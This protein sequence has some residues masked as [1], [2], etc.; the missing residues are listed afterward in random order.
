MLMQ[1]DAGTRTYSTTGGFVALSDA[2]EKLVRQGALERS[3]IRHQA[4]VVELSKSSHF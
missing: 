1:A 3:P 4:A 2:I